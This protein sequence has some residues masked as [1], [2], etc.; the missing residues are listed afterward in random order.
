MAVAAWAYFRTFYPIGLQ[1]SF[2]YQYNAIFVIEAIWYNLKAGMVIPPALLFLLG[3]AVAIR[4]VLGFYVN[5]R[6]FFPFL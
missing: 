2:L 1:V 6:L 3:L 5:C 4:C